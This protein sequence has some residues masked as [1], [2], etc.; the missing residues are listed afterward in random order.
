MV[1]AN[2]TDSWWLKD[3][4]LTAVKA[5]FVAAHKINKPSDLDPTKKFT[6]APYSIGFPTFLQF[7]TAMAGNDDGTPGINGPGAFNVALTAEG[8]AQRVILDAAWRQ[9]HQG[10]VIND[11]VNAVVTLILHPPAAGV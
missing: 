7:C 3:M 2:C 11:F 5:W 9:Q 4:I 6:D 8:C 1:S 10:D